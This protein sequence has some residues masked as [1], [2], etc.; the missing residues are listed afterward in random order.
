MLIPPSILTCLLINLNLNTRHKLAK[1]SLKNSR[2]H[3]RQTKIINSE[4]APKEIVKSFIDLANVAKGFINENQPPSVAQELGRLFPST[5]V[6]GGE[7]KAESLGLV[8]VNRLYRQQ[9][10]QVILVSQH[11]QRNEL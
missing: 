1:H 8:P 6:E 4:N 3:K 9:M 5:R 7:V 10:Q 2:Q 11:L